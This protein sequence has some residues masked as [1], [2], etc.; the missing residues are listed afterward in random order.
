MQM[1]GFGTNANGRFHQNLQTMQRKI[2]K[3]HQQ[4]KKVKDKIFQT[5][6]QGMQHLILKFVFFDAVDDVLGNR[7]ATELKVI[8]DSLSSKTDQDDS[9]ASDCDEDSNEEQQTGD[10]VDD[11]AE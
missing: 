9:N 2:E 10:R 5:V 3:L 1:E 6:Q 8:I 11:S 4:H 7:P